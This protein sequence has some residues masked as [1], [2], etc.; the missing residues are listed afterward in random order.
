MDF[1][2][3]DDLL[4]AGEPGST[5]RSYYK[6]R[7][8]YFLVAIDAIRTNGLG[9]K[10]LEVGPFALPLVRPCRTMDVIPDYSPTYLW[11]ARRV[12]WPILDGSFDLLIALQVWEHL[13]DRQQECFQE[14]R[15]VARNLLLSFPYRWECED[16]AHRGIDDAVILRWAGGVYPDEEWLVA[17]RKVCLYL[18]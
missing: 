9:H 7:W 17:K 14:A 10:V 4:N 11:D 8:P 2:K 18:R 16:Q 12:P 3:E 13:G 15:R 5:V 6:D 1:L